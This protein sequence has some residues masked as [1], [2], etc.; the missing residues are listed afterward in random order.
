MRLFPGGR[1][2]PYQK[3]QKRKRK[4]IVFI[5]KKSYNTKMKRNNEELFFVSS[6]KTDSLFVFVVETKF[7]GIL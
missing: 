2:P 5:N 4:N 1:Q 6:K 3:F 7:L